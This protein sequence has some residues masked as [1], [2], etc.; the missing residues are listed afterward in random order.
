[1][2]SC[3][4]WRTC[5]PP[6]IVLVH[7]S[8]PSPSLFGA[9]AG[10]GGPLGGYIS[11]NFGW[12]SAFLVQIPFLILSSILVFIHLNIKLPR[13]PLTP[14][15]KLRRVDWLGSLTLVVFVAPL[16]AG[17]SLKATEDLEWSDVRVWGSLAT[18]GVAFLAFVF[19]E[20]RVSPE[21]VMPMRL[22]LSRTPLAVSLTNL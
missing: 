18:S 8:F 19:V 10:L 12:R 3:K 15:E 17:F 22:V 9:G 13:T 5:E 21:P 2:V 7:I 16:L 1:M 20:A 11:D 14:I 6:R 4:G